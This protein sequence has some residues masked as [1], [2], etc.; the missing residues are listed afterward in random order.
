[1]RGHAVLGLAFGVLALSCTSFGSEPQPEDAGA[2]AGTDTGADAQ[3]SVK[4][5]CASPPTNTVLC[6]DFESVPASAPF[7]FDFL[8]NPQEGQAALVSVPDRP[9]RVVRLRL[10]RGTGSRNIDLIKD[11]GFQPAANES[12]EL[13]FAM[14]IVEMSL[15]YAVIATIAS[16]AVDYARFYGVASHNGG[17]FGITAPPVR[18]ATLSTG[19]WHKVRVVVAF[20]PPDSVTT[21]TFLDD[22]PVDGRTEFLGSGRKLDLRM[23]VYFTAGNEGAAEV[24]LD[25]IILRRPK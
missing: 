20:S 12:F 17:L 7:G 10:P 4:G 5:P 13:E 1:M 22:K 18:P 9:G 6:F 11:F 16:T 15:D 21:S 25:D 8:D 24:L 19:S 23:G 3:P 14:S 2:D